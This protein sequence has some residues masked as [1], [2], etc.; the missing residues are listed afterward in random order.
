MLRRSLARLDRRRLRL[1]LG[2]FFLALAVP[3]S[4]LIWHARGQLK[5][6]AFH[7]QQQLAEEV[8]ARIDA[9]FADL[10]ASEEARSFADYAFLVVEGDPAQS[11][12]QRSPLS[13]F[14]VESS[15]PGVIGYFQVGADGAFST[16]LLPIGADATSYGVTTEELNARGALQNRIWQILSENELVQRN[17]PRAA[18]N[19]PVER[20]RSA[21]E[22][23]AQPRE[24]GGESASASVAAWIGDAPATLAVPRTST[25]AQAPFDELTAKK[26]SAQGEQKSANVLGRVEDLKLD[27]SRYAAAPEQARRQASIE[28][29][30]VAESRAPRKEK[31]V[32]PETT[33]AAAPASVSESPSADAPTT[34]DSAAGERAAP[35]MAGALAKRAKDAGGNLRVHTF[36]S[37]VD[38]F[39]LSLLGSGEF[40]LFRNVWREGGRYIQGVLIEQ[41]PFL[42]GVAAAA[43]RASTL[44]ATTDLVVAD[45]GDVLALYAGGEGGGYLSEPAELN[46]ALLHR[47]HLTSP[48]NDLELIFSVHRLPPG[49]GASLLYGLAAILA[50]VL[51]GGFWLIY[52][53]GT[54]Q[55]ALARQQQDFVS[56]VSHELKT[57]LTSIRMYGEMLRAGWG[58]DA[59]KQGWYEYIYGESERLSRLI[60]NVLQLARM[61]RNE[62]PLTLKPVSCAEVTDAIRSK[63]ATQV[64]RAGFALDLRCEPD[65]ANTTL[66][67]DAD[68]L[69]QIVINLVDN[70][71]KFSSKAPEKRIEIVLR[72]LHDARLLLSVRDYGPGV[73]KDQ[74]RRIFE[75]FYRSESELTRETVGTG[76]GLALVDQLA[77]AMHARVDVLNR[78]P[79]AE[80]RVLFPV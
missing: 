30:S 36:E 40:V 50:I 51:C 24:T 75:L 9:R 43:F 42:E 76:I 77:R 4:I 29:H 56:A 31:V 44:A 73:P 17:E 1:V 47:T 70:A 61:N 65:A 49:P 71:I 20:D 57:P 80:F 68:A 32:L 67:V 23:E 18:E 60:N 45:R 12:V 37:E 16:P 48:L 63:I 34:T 79:G 14:P 38:P 35:A 69:L 59:Q 62:L 3:A 19:E 55:I 27:D 28:S 41:R 78:E 72:R 22:D 66:R 54:G 7:Q 74:T 8:A 52:R 13:T 58:S 33:V 46:G 39:K 53:L 25:L 6:S 2:V 64:E 15:I 11:F 26:E 21:R 10:V 5:W